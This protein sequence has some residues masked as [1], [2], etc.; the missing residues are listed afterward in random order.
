ML[1]TLIKKKESHY[2]AT[3]TEIY[4]SLLIPVKTGVLLPTSYWL[5]KSQ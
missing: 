5:K 4:P 3:R 2:L 1:Y